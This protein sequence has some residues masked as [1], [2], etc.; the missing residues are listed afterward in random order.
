LV[1]FVVTVFHFI[2][3]LFTI[4]ISCTFIFQPVVDFWKYLNSYLEPMSSSWKVLLRNTFQVNGTST[5]ATT[6]ATF[7]RISGNA[8]TSG[9]QVISGNLNVG[10]NLYGNGQYL[11]GIT[12]GG[13]GGSSLWT[14]GT[15][16]IYYSSTTKP[17][18]GIGTSTPAYNLDVVGNIYQ[19]GIYSHF[20]NLK[21]SGTCNGSGASCIELI[22][23]DNTMNG[24]LIQAVNTSNATTAFVGFNLN[25]NLGDSTYSHFG[26]MYLNSSTYTDPSFGTTNAVPNL[27]NIQ[28][29]IN[30]VSAKPM[31]ANGFRGTVLLKKGTYDVNGSILIEKSGV[32][33]RGEGNSTAGTGRRGP[34]SSPRHRPRQ[35]RGCGGPMA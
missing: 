2:A 23:S 10:G 26:G 12:A 9:N 3:F 21:Y 29:A 18:V 32:I 17:Y 1:R 20:G 33:I 15:N 19:T 13:T 11:T 31:N 30:R 24:I 28:N 16:G 4:A 27:L 5:L 7:L 8:T 25:N 34:R 22:G 14:S 35:T 6:T